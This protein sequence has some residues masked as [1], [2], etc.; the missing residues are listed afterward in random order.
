MYQSLILH[1]FTVGTCRSLCICFDPSKG[2]TTRRKV[3]AFFRHE[4]TMVTENLCGS[5]FIFNM[6]DPSTPNFKAL[7]FNE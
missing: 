6:Y 7:H 1:Y 3:S 5:A 2:R 4:H